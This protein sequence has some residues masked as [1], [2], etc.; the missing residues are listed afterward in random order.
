MIDSKITLQ[1][2]VFRVK[3]LNNEGY[4]IWRVL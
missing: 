2:I 1:Q 4:E 3:E